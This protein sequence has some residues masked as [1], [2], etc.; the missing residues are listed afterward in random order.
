MLA[1]AL[2]LLI[3]PQ[4][5][6][7]ELLR[8]FAV[9]E[10]SAY[11]VNAEMTVESR[12]GSLNTF[13][14]EDITIR[15]LFNTEVTKLETDGFAKMRFIRPTITEIEGETFERP[16]K[17]KIEKLNQD[18]LLTVSPINEVTDV[19]D[20]A[21]KPV[22]TKGGGRWMTGAT[23]ANPIGQFIGDIYRLVLFIGPFDSSLDLAPKLPLDEVNI[24]DTWKKTV[25]YQPQTLKGTQKKA[26]QRLDYTYK[27]EGPK[28]V[29]GKQIIRISAVMDLDTD[30]GAFI[31]QLIGED[32]SKTGLKGIPLQ[33]KGRIDFD[34]EPKTLKTLLA[35]AKTEGGFKVLLTDD[36]DPIAEERF[37][38]QTVL[39]LVK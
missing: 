38:G 16:P 9:G 32:A 39:K 5:K 34:L 15:Y 36:D 35:V 33:V 14:P 10:K 30:L 37:K 17:T 8:K 12:S 1:T 11:S 18:V 2:V 29:N 21:K 6:P 13:I 22:T 20:L 25:G 27:Y 23:Q 19:K 4:A 28:T 3:T 24:G 7:V 26:V 31:N